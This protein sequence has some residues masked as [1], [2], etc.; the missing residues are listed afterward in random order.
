MKRDHVNY[1][2]VGLVVLGALA[3]LLV[4]LFVITGPGSGS[5]VSYYTDYRNVTGLGY[6]APVFYE[7]FRIGQVSDIEPQRDSGRTTY[8]VE[9]AIRRDWPLPANSVAKLA[10]SG[11]L[12]DI[13]IAIREGDSTTMLKAGDLL[14]GEEGQDVFGAVNDL[15]AEVTILTRDRLRPLVENLGN[16]LDSIG[17][18]VDERMPVLM[19][20]AEGLLKRLNLASDSVNKILSTR[21][22]DLIDATLDDLAG[23]A[24]NTRALATELNETRARLDA[25]LDELQTTVAE[26]RPDIR[27]AISDIS[28]ITASLARRIDSISHNLESSSRN[29]NEFSREVRKSPNRLLFTPKADSVIVEDE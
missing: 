18:S 5:S 23:T 4:A 7:G 8:R 17:T 6:G 22:R 12:A 15:A 9:L 3:L 14:K 24:A 10:S 26:N 20:E 1:T 29:L 2:L 11:L 21:N 13:A 27:E 25:L 16:K 19:A 28:Q